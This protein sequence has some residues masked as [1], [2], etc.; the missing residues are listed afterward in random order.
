MTRRRRRAGDDGG[1][2]VLAV[3]ITFPAVLVV[4]ML[5]VQAGLYWHAHQR[6]DAAAVRAAAAAARAGGT[7][8]D[9]H[10]AANDFLAGAPLDN[11]TV[12]VTLDEFAATADVIGTA[13][14]LV[15]GVTGQVQ[16]SADAP[17]ERFVPETERQ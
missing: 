5:A 6:A 16:A 12:T 8:T 11:A 1:A 10:L 17:V 14:S 15:P 13:P 7:T 2:T 3:A 9:G 4:L